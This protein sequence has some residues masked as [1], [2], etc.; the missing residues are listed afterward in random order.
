VSTK[1]PEPWEEM[2]MDF[3]NTSRARHEAFEQLV[4]RGETL[5]PALSPAPTRPDI[6]DAELVPPRE[7]RDHRPRGAVDGADRPDTAD[8]PTDKSATPT[9]PEA[10]VP[11][12]LSQD[13][14]AD[15]M[16]ASGVRKSAVVRKG[17]KRHVRR[18]R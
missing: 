10:P 8:V 13:E 3:A 2:M 4:H 16:R 7:A 12:S 11:R 6:V 1:Q 17:R 15:V 9:A 18:V 14:A 5:P